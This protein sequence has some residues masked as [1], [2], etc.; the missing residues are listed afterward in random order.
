M[1]CASFSPCGSRI[2]AGT[3]KGIILIID[4]VTRYVR[5]A[6]RIRAKSNEQVTQRVQ[7]ANSAIRKIAFDSS[8]R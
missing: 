7:V 6:P 5:L 4:P 8:G 1:C 2:Y 3:T